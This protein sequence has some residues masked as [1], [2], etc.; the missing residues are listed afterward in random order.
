MEEILL[1]RTYWIMGIVFFGIIFP[2]LG[3]IYWLGARN[4]QKNIGIFRV[5]GIIGYFIFMLVYSQDIIVPKKYQVEYKKVYQCGYVD[6][7]VQKYPDGNKSK[8]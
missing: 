5:I 1:M 4:Q 7:M 6:T 2:M 3:V 8:E